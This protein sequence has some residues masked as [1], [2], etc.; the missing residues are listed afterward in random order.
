M[1]V[2]LVLSLMFLSTLV[3]GETIPSQTTTPDD[4]TT[5]LRRE[6]LQWH[7]IAGMATWGLWL[8]TNIEG[9]RALHTLR[10][11]FE[12]EANY[13][14]LSNPQENLLLYY[15]TLQQSEWESTSGLSTHRNLA[16][17]TVSAYALTAAL[18][19]LAPSRVRE[20]DEFDTISAH[21]LLALVHLA[22]IASLPTLGRQIERGGPAA[23]QRMKNVGWAGF[24][25]LTMS[26]AVFYF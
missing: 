19:M 15:A 4:G 6:M 21:K 1:R 8:A 25:A 17:A 14:L 23:A 9:E 16:Y 7:Q 24:G 10:R 18:S 22:A 13:L 20:S 11:K 26:I 5:S 3:H 12:P 2:V